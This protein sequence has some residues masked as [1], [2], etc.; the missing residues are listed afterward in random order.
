MDSG[1]DEGDALCEAR[2]CSLEPS[3]MRVGFSPGHE[4]YSY[5][6]LQPGD[7]MLGTDRSLEVGPL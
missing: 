2:G 4:M 5:L 3:T 1:P 6:V 7:V